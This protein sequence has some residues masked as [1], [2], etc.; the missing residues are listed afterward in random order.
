MQLQRRCIEGVQFRIVHLDH[1]VTPLTEP[2]LLLERA[3]HGL[4]T[5]LAIVDISLWENKLVNA[6]TSKDTDFITL[7][8]SIW[9]IIPAHRLSSEKCGIFHFKRLPTLTSEGRS[10]CCRV[11][12]CGIKLGVAARVQVVNEEWSTSDCTLV[13]TRHQVDLSLVH[14][15]SWTVKARRCEGVAVEPSVE[16]SVVSSY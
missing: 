15:D 2:R 7:L 6:L 4:N 12:L 5:Y 11:D 1:S 3:S 8:A 16:H 9:N 10:V 14:N 13:S